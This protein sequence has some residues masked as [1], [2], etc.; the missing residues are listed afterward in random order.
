MR[1]RWH[2]RVHVLVLGWVLAAAVVAIAHRAVPQAPWLMVHL[3]MLGAVS[4]A[5]LIWSAHF[6]EAVR[7]APLPGGHAGQAVRLALHTVGASAVVS[8]LL[9][10]VWPAVLAGA[11]LVG[12]NGLWHAAVLLT[13]GRGALGVRLGWTAWYFV[14]AA[15]LLPVGAG[16]GALLARADAAGPTAARAYVAHV[17]VMILGWVGLTVVGT[18]VTLWPTM[19][20]VQLADDART[21]AQ[22][23]LAV[24]GAGLALVLAGAATGLR[25][26]AVA[27]LVVHLAG[28]LRATSPLLAEAR[29]R[30]PDT[31]A[32]RS[33]GMAWLWLLATVVIW[34]VAVAGADGWAGAQARLSA[35]IG[36][37]V[38]G[39]AAQVLLGSLSHLGPMV[40]GGGPSA[41]RAARAVVGRGGTARLLL[42]NVG[43]VVFLLPAPSLV[44][45]GVSM[46][47]LGALLAAPVLLVVAAVRARRA[48]RADVDGAA[49][50][51]VTGPPPLV[52]TPTRPRGPGLAALA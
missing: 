2:L 44:R 1:T 52:A 50:A 51:V 8:G 40:L 12:A 30:V 28:L 19:L 31:F 34:T 17:V 3:L 47:V 20:R 38:V 45:V 6:A 21:A 41:V 48:A 16:L 32:A 22:Q 10:E 27:G 49:R 13:Q 11:V 36:P 26:L 4:T 33:V 43:L 39:F 18:M 7:R 23:G 14:V 29:R 9:A 24:L 42:L 25:P 5:I 15:L 46:L 37:P 35:L